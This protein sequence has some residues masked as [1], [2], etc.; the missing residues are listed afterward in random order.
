MI[1]LRLQ[2]WHSRMH[3]AAVVMLI[4]ATFSPLTSDALTYTLVR[5]ES[6]HSSCVRVI[7]RLREWYFM[8]RLQICIGEDI[9]PITLPLDN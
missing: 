9:Y 7:N 8:L 6:T 1:G 4:P 5:Y 3:L 2:K